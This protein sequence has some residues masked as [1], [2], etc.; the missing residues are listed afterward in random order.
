MHTVHAKPI[1]G[2]LLCGVAGFALLFFPA[3]AGIGVILLIVSVFALSLMP[4]RFLIQFSED[5]LVL[6]NHQDMDMCTIIY[7]DEIVNWQYE[8]HPAVDVLTVNL[9]NGTSESIEL[10]SKRPIIRF[11]NQYA[12]GKE[13]R[14]SRR[15]DNA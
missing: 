4:D 6:Y 7:W 3:A 12:P 5:Y 9:V 1:L 2:L 10:Y 15:K 8:Y 14:S 11:M 13:I